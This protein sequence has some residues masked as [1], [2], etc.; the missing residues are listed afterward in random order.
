MVQRVSGQTLSNYSSWSVG[1]AMVELRSNLFRQAWIRDGISNRGQQSVSMIQNTKHCTKHCKT[2]VTITINAAIYV[3]VLQFAGQTNDR[4][5]CK[6]GKATGLY[7]F[8]LDV[9]LCYKG[10]THRETG[11]T[12]HDKGRT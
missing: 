9:Q 5:A 4:Q 2:T 11:T 8:F 3:R 6:S 1:Q 7:L 12:N 10:H